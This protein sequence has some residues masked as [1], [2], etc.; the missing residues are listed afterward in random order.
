MASHLFLECLKLNFVLVG[1]EQELQVAE[2][3]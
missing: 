2:C 1:K 3:F